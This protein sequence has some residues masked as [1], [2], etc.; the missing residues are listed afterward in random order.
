[1]TIGVANLMSTWKYTAISQFTTQLLQ[2][3][4]GGKSCVVNGR[5]CTF[6]CK[7]NEFKIV[8]FN[9]RNYSL[10][11]TV[12]HIKILFNITMMKAKIPNYI[13]LT[14]F[15]NYWIML[16]NKVELQYFNKIALKRINIYFDIFSFFIYKISVARVILALC[17]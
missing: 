7:K 15:L 9:F 2:C 6:H 8:H 1:M 17:S 14:T 11:S 12:Q 3:V 16:S 10:R 5:S 13:S 4:A